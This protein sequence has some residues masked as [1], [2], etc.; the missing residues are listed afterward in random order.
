[1]GVGFTLPFAKS[2]GSIGY[3]ETTVD[4][5]A[6]TKEN[7]KSLIVTNWGERV[8][9]FKFG[10]NLVEFLFENEG[11]ADTKARIT[12]RIE[13]QVATWLPFVTIE[14][15]MITFASEDSSLQEHCMRVRIRFRISGK[16]D[17][18]AILDFTTP[19]IQA[20]AD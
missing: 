5:I 11:R 10:C 8:C 2:T 20:V 1:M 16:P 7:L 4:E 6:A 19:A 14:D 15:V 18:S 17:F 9:H 12:E 3:L 13:S